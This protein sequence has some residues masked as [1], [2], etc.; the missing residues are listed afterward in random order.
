MASP[1]ELPI[2]LNPLDLIKFK[3]SKKQIEE[4]KRLE[5]DKVKEGEGKVLDIKMSLFK[6]GKCVVFKEKEKIVVIT[7]TP[8]ME[9]KAVTYPI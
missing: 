4:I 7:I 1:I 9:T 3:F 5:D 6:R 8:Q 2:P